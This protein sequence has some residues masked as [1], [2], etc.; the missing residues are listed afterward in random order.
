MYSKKGDELKL[1]NCLETSTAVRTN[2]V[3]YKH[4]YK[5]LKWEISLN[6][7]W[8]WRHV[9]EVKQNLEWLSTW[10]HEIWHEWCNC[11]ILLLATNIMNETQ[12]TT[13]HSSMAYGTYN[14]KSNVCKSIIYNFIFSLYAKQWPFIKFLLVLSPILSNFCLVDLFVTCCMITYEY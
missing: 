11:I 14:S 6:M 8:E 2:L 4:Y 5:P 12:V 9:T 7:P 1:G 10:A 13:F 3:Q